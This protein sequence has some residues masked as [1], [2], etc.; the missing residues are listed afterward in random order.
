MMMFRVYFPRIMFLFCSDGVKRTK[1]TFSITL[2]AERN[3]DVPFYHRSPTSNEA[4]RIAKAVTRLPEFLMQR[5][6]QK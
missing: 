2:E 1:T 3:G 5:Q 4:R 6:I